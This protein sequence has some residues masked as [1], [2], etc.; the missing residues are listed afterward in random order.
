MSSSRAASC[1][2]TPSRRCRSDPH[3]HPSRHPN[4]N[5]TPSR[6]CRSLFTLPWAF[7]SS[8]SARGELSNSARPGRE[9]MAKASAAAQDS[10]PDTK[11]R[12]P[13]NPALAQPPERPA[14]VTVDGNQITMLG[15]FVS[16]FAPTT[17]L[18]ILNYR[19][20]CAPTATSTALAS[21]PPPLPP[22]PPPP[23]PS[24]PPPPPQ[25]PS[26]GRPPPLPPALPPTLSRYAETSVAASGQWHELA[27]GATTAG[28]SLTG[29]SAGLAYQ[30]RVQAWTATID[31]AAC[32]GG[33]TSACSEWSAP[34][35]FTTAT[36]ARHW[37]L[38]TR[39]SYLYG[40]GS[41]VNPWPMDLQGAIDHPEV[42][43]SRRRANPPH[44]RP[45]RTPSTPLL[46]LPPCTAPLRTPLAQPPSHSPSHSSER[47]PRRAHARRCSTAPS[48]C[49]MRAST[50]R[51]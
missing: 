6:R 41:A 21:P 25:P 46:A 1:C 50:P 39:G 28:T 31:S 35:N 9:G 7:P 26:H 49:C 51:R 17:T 43:A 27:L 48:C 36:T 24:P 8:P 33:E 40:N 34:T 3:P 12:P 5:A 32:L 44:S 20:Q 14:A 16:W 19:L 29:L 38:S 37:H 2:A 10:P 4:P 30:V 13:P 11:R 15:A 45:F 47:A 23:L 42:C 22:P 18:P